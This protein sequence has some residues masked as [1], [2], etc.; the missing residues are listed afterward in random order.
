[1][2]SA[3]TKKTK[4]NEKK[5]KRN[6][7]GKKETLQVFFFSSSKVLMTEVG[8]YVFSATRQEWRCPCVSI[9]S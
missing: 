3:K 1:M 9:A 6:N 7:N 4:R 5:K 8:W 2:E